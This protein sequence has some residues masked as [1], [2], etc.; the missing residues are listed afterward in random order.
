MLRGNGSMTMLVLYLSLLADSGIMG[1]G[2]RRFTLGSHT[3]RYLQ[4]IT[5]MVER[6][7]DPR[8]G[9]GPNPTLYPEIHPDASPATSRL[10]AYADAKK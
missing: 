4:E 1:D 6:M 5:L 7:Q 8:Q 10:A 2:G 9:S 3:A